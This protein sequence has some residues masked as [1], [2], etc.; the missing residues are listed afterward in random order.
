M[1]H[2]IW[3]NEMV[4]A[5]AVPWHGLG[6]QIDSDIDGEELKK[7]LNLSPV[8]LRTLYAD[9]GDGSAL[10]KV[11]SRKAVIRTNEN[12]VI[13]V[14]G[15]DFTPIQDTDI[16]DTLDVLRSE[17]LCKFE[18]AGILREGSRFFVMLHV[19]NGT[20]KLK[21]P[22]G[23]TDTVVNFLGV[24]HGHDGSLAFEFTPTNVRMVCQNTVTM[25]RAEAK[26]ARVS[27]YIKHTTNADYRIKAA[28]EA[29]RNVIK[30]NAEVATQ[31][32]KL[33]ATPFDAE[34]VSQMVTQLFPVPIGKEDN[35]PAGTLKSR[36]EVSRLV[37]E[38]KGHQELGIVGTAWGAY[39][40]VVEYFDWHRQTRG[41]KE[42]S[43]SEKKNKMWEATQFNP[44]VYDKKLQALSI[45]E[46][47][48]AA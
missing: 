15:T 41:D 32:E 26:R 27:F 31:A 36:Y 14:V 17:G 5:G 46:E 1:A 28:V 20:L 18:T 12:M 42:L 25:A 10:I 37:V 4:Y 19:P 30:F 9:P 35:I 6:T 40:A 21:T 33:I 47:I 23:K 7:M 48:A 22:N 29:Y 24:S 8:A 16:V 13:G 38:G 34:Q 2:E 3:N 44:Q 11:D 45:I 43:Q 39:N